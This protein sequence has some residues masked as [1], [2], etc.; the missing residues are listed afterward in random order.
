VLDIDRALT[1]L[2]QSNERISEI[3]EQRYLLGQTV[4]ELAL[5]YN[6]SIST[7]E[8]DLRFARAW[9]TSYCKRNPRSSELEDVDFLDEVA[10]QMRSPRTYFG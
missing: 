6:V 5:M 7:V 1:V 3:F 8:R 2:K 9:L 10:D 4:E